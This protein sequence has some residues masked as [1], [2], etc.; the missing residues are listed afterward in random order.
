MQKDLKKVRRSA[1][2]EGFVFV[3]RRKHVKAIAP[4]G[5]IFE[6]SKTPLGSATLPQIVC[7]FSRSGLE[8]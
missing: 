5:A 7:Q 2:R 6:L 4:D 1:Q 8:V 3:D